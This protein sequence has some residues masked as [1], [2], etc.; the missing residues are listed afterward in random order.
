MRD[1]IEIVELVKANESKILNK[2]DKE[3]IEIYKFLQH[4]FLKGNITKNCLFQFVYRSFYRLDNAGLTKEF[5]QEYFNIMEE[6]RGSDNVNPHE[7]VMRLYNFERIKGDN[8][9]QFSFTTKLINTV[10]NDYPIYDAEIAKVFGFSKY[11]LKDL[12]K[13]INKYLDKHRII[14]DTYNKIIKDKLLANTLEKFDEKFY[15]NN[16]TNIKKIDFVIWAC[17]KIMQ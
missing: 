15:E 9:I 8:S 6:Y 14:Y 10:K 2:I 11:N 13:K 5:K 1:I 3:S 12:E 17:G 16:L 7:I 4:E